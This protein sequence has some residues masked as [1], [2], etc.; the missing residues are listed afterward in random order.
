MSNTNE[1]I[2]IEAEFSDQ[3]P[4]EDLILVEGTFTPSEAKEVLMSLINSK[5]S[6]HNLKNLRSYE[7][8]GSE[9]KESKKRITELEKMRKKLLTIL[10]DTDKNGVSVKIESQ[11]NIEFLNHSI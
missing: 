4:T 10:K 7:R 1:Q 2:N 3:L 8:S 11:I 5:I 9:D 6:F